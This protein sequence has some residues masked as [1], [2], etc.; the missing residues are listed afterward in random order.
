M[1]QTPELVVDQGQE[2]VE[3]VFV[4]LFPVLQKLGHLTAGVV[5]HMN[6]RPLVE[7]FRVYSRVL[8][9]SNPL[10]SS[11]YAT[12]ALNLAIAFKAI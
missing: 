8:R 2:I 9:P 7:C 11:L 10:L 4:A 12:R 1:S 6:R 5:G 3:G